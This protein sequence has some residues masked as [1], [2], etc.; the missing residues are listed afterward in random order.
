MYHHHRAGSVNACNDADMVCLY[1]AGYGEKGQIP[2]LCFCVLAF[3]FSASVLM[4]KPPRQNRPLERFQSYC[5]GGTP[6]TAFLKL[7]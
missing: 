7:F 4:T 3:I 1:R 2:R 6:K 5:S